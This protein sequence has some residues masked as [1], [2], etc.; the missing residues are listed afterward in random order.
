MSIEKS[1]LELSERLKYLKSFW[2]ITQK[3]MADKMGISLSAYKYYEKGERDA[4]AVILMSLYEFGVNPTWLFSGQGDIFSKAT[5]GAI[6][7]TDV[8]HSELVKDFKQ[9]E[10]AK[11]CNKIM[12]E[13][14][15]ID[16]NELKEIH[17]FLE[18]KYAKKKAS[19]SHT[20]WN[21]QERRKKEAS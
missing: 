9:K 20:P 12:I 13:L 15:K 1:R 18:F 19:G 14:E 17:E 3:D 10:L 5:N 21:G 11:E 8:A 4:P 6:D 7:I 16:P 2:G